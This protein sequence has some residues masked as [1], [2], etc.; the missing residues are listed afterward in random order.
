MD[1]RTPVRIVVVGGGI[2]GLS[3]ARALAEH[4]DRYR[5]TV[6]EKED[7]VA[8]HQSG[9]NSGVL[10]SGIYYT[11]G[12]LKARLCTDGLR[13]MVDFCRKYDVPHEICGKV[14]VATEPDEI[15]LLEDIEARGRANRVRCRMVGTDELAVLEPAVRGARA[16]HV[17]DAGIADFAAV[18]RVLRDLLI[19]AG[20]EIVFGAQVE[21]IQPSGGGARVH[22]KGL[23]V[24]A[25]V[26]VN[27]AGLHADRIARA[28]GVNPDMRIIPFRGLYY[29][30]QGEARR[31]CRNLIYPVPDPA[32]PF[33]GV[34]LT[35]RTDGRIECGPN[36]VIATGRQAYSLADTS[37]CDLAGSIT[38]PG[39]VRLAAEHWR[40]GL[41]ELKRTLSSRA[42]ARAVQKL[43]PAVRHSDIRYVRSGIRAQAMRTDGSLVDD[44]VIL[45][46]GGAWHVCNAPSPAATAGLSIGRTIA[47]R[48]EQKHGLD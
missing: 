29:E 3:T 17:P 22:G 32:Y 48:V 47:Q 45:Q 33:L 40:T 25:D 11:P 14:I 28:S 31:L 12:S 39:F 13:Q 37:L 18:C 2:V 5:I 4:S 36:A 19:D 34:H 24:D 8:M 35:R 42:F 7:A 38:Y 6:L 1:A 15:P 46:Q 26:V 9:R 20:H 44:F 23:D 30:L 27:C 41:A 43:V 21:R 10:H 16:L